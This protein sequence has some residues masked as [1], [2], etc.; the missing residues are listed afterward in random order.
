MLDE[1]AIL[2]EKA[3]AMLGELLAASKPLLPQF[4]AS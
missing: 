4:R 3:E 1:M 2:P